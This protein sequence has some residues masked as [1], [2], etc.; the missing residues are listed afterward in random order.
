MAVRRD[1]H[2]IRFGQCAS[3][4]TV[5]TRLVPTIRVV[6]GSEAVSLGLATHVSDTPREAA[7]ELA[8]EIAG[9]SPSA[10]RAAKQLLNQADLVSPGEGLALEAE[11]QQG[12]IGGKN[13]IEAVLAN[14]QKR[15][16]EFDDPK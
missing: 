4:H 7:Y 3:W 15:D 11:L 13:Q 2:S 12:L 9:R 16:P 8:R 14:L 5:A 1:Q 10:V 6:S